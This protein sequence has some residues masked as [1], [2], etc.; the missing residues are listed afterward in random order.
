MSAK[1]PPDLYLLLAATL[2][3]H[4]Q[5]AFGVHESAGHAEHGGPLAI[6]LN[7]LTPE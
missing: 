6:G 5:A 2:F 4:R 7:T 1:T 3:A